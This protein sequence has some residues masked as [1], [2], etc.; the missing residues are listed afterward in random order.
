MTTKYTPIFELDGNHLMV[1]E[2]RF[3]FDTRDE[4]VA[5]I[6]SPAYKAINQVYRFKYADTKEVV[7][8]DPVRG[9]SVYMNAELSQLKLLF[10]SGPVFDMG[11]A[12]RRKREIRKAYKE[13][14]KNGGTS[15]TVL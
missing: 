13:T 15:G 3:L 8:E 9:V 5:Y 6:L 2:K 7:M 1:M 4:V 11:I 14:K 10:I 12:E